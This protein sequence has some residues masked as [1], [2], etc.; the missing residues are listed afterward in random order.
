MSPAPLPEDEVGQTRIQQQQQQQQ[1]VTT[2]VSSSPT[3]VTNGNSPTKENGNKVGSIKGKGKQKA[4]LLDKPR[5]L[6]KRNGKGKEKERATKE[7]APVLE[8]DGWVPLILPPEHPGAYAEEIQFVRKW[9][10]HELRRWFDA[11]TLGL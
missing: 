7:E 3:A 1:Q 10:G 11:V 2:S 5:K 8:M 6:E 9:K 4:E